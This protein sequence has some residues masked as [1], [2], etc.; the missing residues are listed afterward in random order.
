V[1]E[2]SAFSSSPLPLALLSSFPEPARHGGSHLRFFSLRL[3]GPERVV[4]E[5]NSVAHLIQQFGI[6][7]LGAGGKLIGVF[8]IPVAPRQKLK[9]ITPKNCVFKKGILWA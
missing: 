5:S 7:A 6:V 2:R 8:P 3:L 1:F 9:R 4:S